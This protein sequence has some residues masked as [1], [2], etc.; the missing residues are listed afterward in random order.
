M[1][2][3]VI[4]LVSAPAFALDIH[5]QAEQGGLV[6]GRAAAGAAVYLDGAAVPVD[7]AGRFVLGFGRDAGPHAEVKAVPAGGKAEVR[8][9]ER[10]NFV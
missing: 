2:Y 6:S 5:G 9:I 7:P 4:T 3:E 8:E 10:N 1:L